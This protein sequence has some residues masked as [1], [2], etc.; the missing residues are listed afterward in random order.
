VNRGWRTAVCVASGP[1][2]APEDCA[3]VEA[4]RAAGSV[5]VVVVN[6]CW[7]LLPRADCLY[8]ADRKWW[9]TYIAAVRAGSSSE[10]WTTSRDG[11]AK[12]GLRY[13]ETADGCQP[14]PLD[15][16]VI[17]KGSNSGFQAIML[18]RHFGASRI[19]LLGYDMQRTGGK[20]HWFGNHPRPLTQGNPTNWIARFNDGAPALAAEGTEVINASRPTALSCFPRVPL[21]L[22]LPGS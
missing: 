22:A 3:L 1:S 4:A 18:A 12:H 17:S 7:R 13:I 19:I 6:D 11:A 14:L 10:L 15:R 16:P 21:V 20:A 5:N 8:A 2:L 9:D